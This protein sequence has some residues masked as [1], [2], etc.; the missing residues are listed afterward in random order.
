MADVFPKIQKMLF[1]VEPLVKGLELIH[2]FARGV[3]YPP[4]NIVKVDETSYIVEVEAA[5]FTKDELHIDLKEGVLTVSG[6]LL[7]P[8]AEVAYV[9]HGFSAKDFNRRFSLSQTMTLTDATFVNGVL[10]V[11]LQN[12]VPEQKVD[13]K[14]E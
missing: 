9:W 14:E 7:E 2:A 10:K 5:G 4:Y 1:S 8:P 6:A 3:P 11:F 13:I 12:V